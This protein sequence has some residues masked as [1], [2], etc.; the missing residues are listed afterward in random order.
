[1][2][3]ACADPPLTRAPTPTVTLARAFSRDRCSIPRD[4]SNWAISGW[5]RMASPKR[6]REPS[7][8]TPGP[9]PKC[10]TSWVTAS[11]SI[12]GAGYD[13]VRTAHRLPPWCAE[14]RADMAQRTV[15]TLARSST[16]TPGRQ[17]LF[18]ASARLATTD[19]THARAYDVLTRLL[20]RDPLARLGAGQAPKVPRRSAHPFSTVRYSPGAAS[21]ATLRARIYRRATRRSISRGSRRAQSRLTHPAAHDQVR[22]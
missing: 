7:P 18:R 21:L 9:W 22:G 10:S 8:G 5:P 11:R 3:P 14:E 17:K 15:T 20:D 16:G 4:T 13:P 1:M 6:P 12:G 19:D 2:K